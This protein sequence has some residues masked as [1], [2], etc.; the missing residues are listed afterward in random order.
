MAALKQLLKLMRIYQWTKSGF[1]FLPLI[2]SDVVFEIYRNPFS[3][4]SLNHLSNLLIAF[5]AFSL[6]AS[7]VYIMNDYRD[8]HEDARD[9]RKKHR[10]LASGKLNPS[11]ALV[12]LA[13]I[14]LV[15][16]AGAI[17][18][19]IDTFYILGFYFILN[20]FYTIIGKRIILGDV[21]I[22]SIGYILRVMVGANALGVVTSP[23][24]VITTFFLS[25][26]LGFFK[27]Y[28]EVVTS[29]PEEMIGGSYDPD[30]LKTFTTITATMSIVSYSTY[31]ILGPHAE[32]NLVLT[33]PFVVLGVFRYYVLLQ[34]PE[35]L[36]DGNP[37]DLL[38]ADWYL[39]LDIFA[40]AALCAYLIISSGL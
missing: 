1:I 7:A 32:A 15:G 35:K 28:Y 30:V 16:L 11:L 26:F 9:P 22:I 36:K 23:W 25:L 37:S 6:T 18:I 40:W 20:I 38:L 8:R 24:V 39:I 5:F 3:E 17:R 14:L 2:F 29:G 19:G 31:T 34:S 13:L 27:R 4:S 10:P 33:V 12:F 21:F